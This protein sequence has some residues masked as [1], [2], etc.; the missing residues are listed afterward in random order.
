MQN[1][2][3]RD[4][5]HEARLK[6]ALLFVF[7]MVIIILLAIKAT[8]GNC[9][10]VQTMGNRYW[11][12]DGYLRGAYGDPKNIWDEI[13]GIERGQEIYDH[14]SDAWYWL[15]ACHNGAVATDK[16]V[17]MPYVFH[18]ETTPTDGKWVRY[19][20][21]GRMIKGWY[22]IL[23]TD[24]ESWAKLY[25][26][27]PITGAMIKGEQIIYTMNGLPYKIHFDE[28]TGEVHDPNTLR[29]LVTYEFTNYRLTVVSGY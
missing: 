26:Y 2:E 17:W 5:T 7:V 21:G 18:G 19:D 4:V 11:Y 27:D 29:G 3:I 9:Y 22:A 12:E 23:D 20:R 28:V 10:F 24:Q 16:E 1:I 8:A 13:Y 14:A 15:D 6:K 25:L